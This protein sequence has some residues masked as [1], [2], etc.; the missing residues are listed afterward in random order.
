MNPNLV[1]CCRRKHASALVVVLITAAL[2]ATLALGIV[3]SRSQ[4]MKLATRRQ[5]DELAN[6]D[7][8]IQGG[9][10]KGLLTQMVQNQIQNQQ[11]AVNSSTG[12]VSMSG[13][14]SSALG[15][16]LGNG[17]LTTDE[18][19]NSSTAYAIAPGPTPTAGPSVTLYQYTPSSAHWFQPLTSDPTDPL[20]GIQAGYVAANIPL[21]ID[22]TPAGS[23]TVFYAGQ[24]VTN[25]YVFREVPLSIYSLY[26]T[27]ATTLSPDMVQGD[28]GRVYVD[29]N[30]TINGAVTASR[31]LTAQGG[32]QGGTGS[33][34][35]QVSQGAA[36]GS[37]VPTE[38]V[39]PPAAGAVDQTGALVDVL[40][41]MKY[42]NLI[43]GAGIEERGVQ[44]SPATYFND[45]VN[46]SSLSQLQLGHQCE[47]T[48][49][50]TSPV[51]ANS[52][53]GMVQVTDN[54]TGTA[55]A[56]PNT[57]GG[58]AD[59]LTQDSNAINLPWDV[60][61]NGLQ[62]PPGFR[63]ALT[64]NGSRLVNSANQPI[65]FIVLDYAHISALL[66]PMN[67]TFYI[68][69]DPN[70]QAVLLRGGGTTDASNN[71]TGQVTDGKSWN[72]NPGFSLVTNLDIYVYQGIAP[73][74]GT[75]NVAISLITSGVVHAVY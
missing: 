36:Q 37:T 46:P 6:L 14:L 8:Q 63:A 73:A 15:Q 38:T 29:G 34:T 26:A 21:E 53:N 2:C 69:G 16:V 20:W 57:S 10:V 56:L 33:D 30:L 11:I 44:V 12:T 54:G 72:G 9:H 19:G 4:S 3:V 67:Q 71:F 65:Q 7:S 5:Q 74:P 61:S 22:A 1:P 40:S 23:N 41:Q 55:V 25:T 52:G 70:T 17:S 66:Q 43:M 51:P 68:P 49:T 27:G 39:T 62:L 58:F 47:F 42:G 31:P 59:Q 28:A 24:S 48:V 64:S 32:I 75:N 18:D 45:L 60:L 35:L 13:P 50:Y